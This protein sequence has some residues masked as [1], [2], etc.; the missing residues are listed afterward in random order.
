MDLTTALRSTGA[1]RAYTAEPVPDDVVYRILD[2]ARF[3]PSGGNRQ[4]WR[5]V[6]VKDP[7]IRRGLR[8]FNR[9]ALREYF[10]IQAAGQRAFNL[11]DHGRWSGPAGVDLPAA[12][13]N[14]APLPVADDFD[15]APVMLAVLVELSQLAAVDVELDRHGMAAG[16]SIYPFCWQIVLA[17]RAQGLAGVMTTVAVRYE[18]DVLRLLGAPDG[19]ALAAIVTLG[20]VGK[21][22]TKLKRK[23]VEG[24]TT[25]DRFDGSP[26]SQQHRGPAEPVTAG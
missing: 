1:G 25:V 3:A 6:V 9:L 24:F 8:D 10:A 14:E 7:A 12:R 22:V 13:A 11:G 15:Q 17:A 16:A 2:I 21:L 4:P 19:W 23:L 18:P 26:L 5:V 20:H